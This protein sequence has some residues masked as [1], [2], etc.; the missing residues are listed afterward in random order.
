MSSNL[1]RPKLLEGW[2]VCFGRS[3]INKGT[4][5]NSMAQKN[6]PKNPKSYPSPQHRISKNTA[7]GYQ[8]GGRNLL[9][10]ARKPKKGPPKL[11]FGGG[12]GA[13]CASKMKIRLKNRG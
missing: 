7:L 10:A 9:F 2:S 12:G 13:F 6:L 4:E 1:L 11:I 3:N 8:L 5:K